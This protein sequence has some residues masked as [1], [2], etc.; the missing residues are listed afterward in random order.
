MR[1]RIKISV[2]RIWLHHIRIWSTHHI[3]GRPHA[4]ERLGSVEM[5]R[6]ERGEV[7]ALVQR[8]L[9]LRQRGEDIRML[10]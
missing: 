1:A 7:A 9:D 4:L 10:R 3:V 5:L 2:A 8:L 6:W